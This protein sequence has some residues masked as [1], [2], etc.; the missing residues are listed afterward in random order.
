MFGSSLPP[1]VCMRAQV[2]LMFLCLF[3]YS[4]IQ[5]ILCTQSEIILWGRLIKYC[6]RQKKVKKKKGGLKI[7]N[8]YSEALN[9]RTDNTM[10]KRKRSYNDLQKIRQKELHLNLRGKLMCSRR[11]WFSVGTVYVVIVLRI[12]V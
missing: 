6:F 5:N 9:H 10:A 2:L 7:S 3:V 12:L 1:V 4:G 11:V 8:G